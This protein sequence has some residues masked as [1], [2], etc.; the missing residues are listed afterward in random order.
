M[1]YPGHLPEP[2]FDLML[3]FFRDSARLPGSVTEQLD[4]I[5]Q[6]LLDASHEI[7]SSEA[8]DYLSQGKPVSQSLALW[9]SHDG[10]RLQERCHDVRPR[11]QKKNVSLD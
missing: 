6:P 5:K 2:D 1:V 7:L 11:Q 3:A 4:K 9:I 10:R 8:F